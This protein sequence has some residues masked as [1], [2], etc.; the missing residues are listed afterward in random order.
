MK[1]LI[2]III[3]ILSIFVLFSQNIEYEKTYIPLREEQYSNHHLTFGLLS[4][5]N[6]H[7]VTAEQKTGNNIYL[8]RYNESM[9][10]VWQT[11]LHFPIE[12][13]YLN[14]KNLYFID[15]KIVFFVALQESIYSYYSTFTKYILSLNGETL[16]Y[17][18]SNSDENLIW[19]MPPNFTRYKQDYLLANHNDFNANPGIL[20]LSMN[21]E[22]LD[23]FNC[24]SLFNIDPLYSLGIS[25]IVTDGNNYYFTLT[26]GKETESDRSFLIIKTNEDF[27]ILWQFEIDDLIINRFFSDIITITENGNYAISLIKHNPT[28]KNFDAILYIIKPNGQ[29]ELFKEFTYEKYNRIRNIIYDKNGGYLLIGHTGSHLE[30]HNSNLVIKL[31]Q[32]NEIAWEKIWGPTNNESYWLQFG[33]YIGNQKYALVGNIYYR[34]ENPYY[35]QYSTYHSIIKDL[36]ASVETEVSLRKSILAFPNPTR[37]YISVKSE[38]SVLNSIP[39]IFDLK[40]NIVSSEKYSYS[41]IN[42]FTI[43]FSFN[44]L[45]DGTYIIK[46]GTQKTDKSVKFQIIN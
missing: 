26:R 43:I 39:A 45:P 3:F 34:A 27:E 29:V 37:S 46:F 15:N 4:L 17:I 8:T 42:D 2:N 25:D 1:L 30:H 13:N 23:Y 10:I 6:N 11:K 19:G 5:P 12:Y 36:T 44:Y 9:E 35:V 41:I 32:N 7:F 14:L 20:L 21:G 33:R 40:G 18:E 16:D 31:D 28:T 22:I 24:D 38:S